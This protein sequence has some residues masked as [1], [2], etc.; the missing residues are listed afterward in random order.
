MKT[1]AI[2]ATAA[3]ALA[4]C[5][6]ASTVINGSEAAAVIPQARKPI[7]RGRCAISMP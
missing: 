2:I 6:P 4:A 3:L 7:S 5:N 1:Y